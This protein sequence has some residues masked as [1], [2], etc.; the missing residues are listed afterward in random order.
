MLYVAFATPPLGM[1]TS[2]VSRGRFGASTADGVVTTP[3]GLTRFLFTLR[4]YL[5][6]CGNSMT[7]Q[8]AVEIRR[9]THAAN[10]VPLT[11]N[12]QKLRSMNKP[13]KASRTTGN[14]TLDL[15]LAPETETE[16]TQAPVG[17]SDQQWRCR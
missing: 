9:N 16:D 2:P 12:A 4:T 6:P 7:A 11:I 13:A 5:N 3:L 14:P 15:L 10:N 8:Q 1:P 17:G